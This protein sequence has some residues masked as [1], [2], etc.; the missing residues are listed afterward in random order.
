VYW[1]ASAFEDPRAAN[2]P[3]LSFHFQTTTPV[4]IHR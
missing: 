3:F 4:S 2:L 1:H